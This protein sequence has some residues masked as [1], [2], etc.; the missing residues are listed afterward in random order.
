MPPIL[1]EP[2]HQASHCDDGHIRVLGA[3]HIAVSIGELLS[4][5]V[6]SSLPVRTS[7]WST[8][9]EHVR[10]WR[11]LLADDASRTDPH[12]RSHLSLVVRLLDTL[13]ERHC[14]G[15]EPDRETWETVMPT[16]AAASRHLDAFPLQQRKAA[17]RHFAV[18][19]PS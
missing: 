16:I 17:S 10:A 3:L 8:L 6:R 4:G 5:R 12:T 14:A 11:L 1:M 13:L 7:Q 18:Y 2:S 19:R 9:G 15:D